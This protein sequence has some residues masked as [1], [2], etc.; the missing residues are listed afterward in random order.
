MLN[1]SGGQSAR[2]A[3]TGRDVIYMRFHILEIYILLLLFIVITLTYVQLYSAGSPEQEHS[4]FMP[5]R[6]P[7]RG[8]GR[9]M[10]KAG[11][12]AHPDPRG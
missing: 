11:G 10:L 12:V 8:Q 7:L 3:P 9:Q 2:A 6:T 5:A 1:Y 4:L